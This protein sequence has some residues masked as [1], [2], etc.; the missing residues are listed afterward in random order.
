M[1][2]GGR[3]FK[4]TNA[5]QEKIQFKYYSYLNNTKIL[6]GNIDAKYENTR[7]LTTMKISFL[8]H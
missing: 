4:F 8:N 6:L 1:Y 5:G 2:A 3:I 7:S